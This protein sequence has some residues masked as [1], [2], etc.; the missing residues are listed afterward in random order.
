MNKCFMSLI[1]ALSISA[2]VSVSANDIIYTDDIGRMHFMGR[3]GYSGVRN[4]QMGEMQSNAI[5]DAAINIQ[6]TQK[7][8]E[9]N[10]S[11]AEQNYK[12]EI[13]AKR[14]RNITDVIKDNSN[15][16]VSSKG[17]ANFTSEQRKMDASSPY[18]MGNTNI[19]NATKGVNDAKTIYT[20]DLG[21]LH[22]FGKG[23]VVKD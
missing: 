16:P 13:N 9:Q 8:V 7:E 14:E 20:D 10:L 4:L 5:N 22:F 12:N 6:K 11:E 17:K 23:N 18:G 19:P 15:V 21:R 2:S 1:L 3:G